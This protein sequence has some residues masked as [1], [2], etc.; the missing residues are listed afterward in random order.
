MDAPSRR[1]DVTQLVTV[2]EYA[3]EYRVTERTVYY[4]IEKGAV[5]VR[6]HGPRGGIRI[7]RS[8]D[9]AY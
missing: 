5:E 9:G 1:R 7:I 2:K 6:R 8:D 4:W 3:A